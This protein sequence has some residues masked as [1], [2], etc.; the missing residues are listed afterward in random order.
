MSSMTRVLCAAACWLAAM[1]ASCQEIVIGQSVPLTGPLADIGRDIRDGALAWFTKVNAAG[2]VNGRKISLVT[3]D[4]ANNKDRATENTQKLLGERGAV[5]LFGFASATLSTN[6]IPIAEKA[7]AVFFAPAS[8]SLSIRDKP[9][10]FTT[11]AS[12][13]EEAEKIVNHQKSLGATRTVI[14]HYDDPVGK[15][16]YEAVAAVA[17]ASGLAKPRAIAIRRGAKL[18]PTILDAVLADSPHYVIATTRAEPVADLLK[19]MAE[20]GRQ[21]PISALSFVNPDELASIAGAGARGTIVS[22]VVPTP[23]T[24]PNINFPVVKECADAVAAVNSAQFNY[25]T[26]ESCLAAKVLVE[27]IKRAGP[28]VGRSSLVKGIESLGRLDLGGVQMVFGPG[29]H[30]GSKWVDLTILSRGNTYRN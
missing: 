8:G 19:V 17:V 14:L 9:L 23:R 3:L 20:K 26:L 22:Q 18:D 24:T 11:R 13:R 4:D 27:A 29:S 28:S 1:N 15:S 5:A 12:Y 25:T 21:V 10:V 2:G 16:N 6:A 30:H 7:G